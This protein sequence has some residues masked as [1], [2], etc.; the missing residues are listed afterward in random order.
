MKYIISHI[1]KKRLKRVVFALI[2]LGGI[3]SP[4]LAKEYLNRKSIYE[5]VINRSK[6]D[7]IIK[8]SWYASRLLFVKNPEIYLQSDTIPLKMMESTKGFLELYQTKSRSIKKLRLLMQSVYR[9]ENGHT[10]KLSNIDFAKF[11]VIKNKYTLKNRRVHSF[12]YLDER[13]APLMSI[14]K[15]TSS[16][17]TS[18]ELAFL[19][20]LRLKQ[21]GKK[22]WILY[23]MNQQAYI[24]VDK[25]FFLHGR[26]ISPVPLDP[27]L[28]IFNN[29]FC[30]SSVLKRDDRKRSIALSKLLN[31][32]PP[33]KYRASIPTMQKS[34]ISKILSQTYIHNKLDKTAALHAAGRYTLPL[35][36]FQ[37]Y[38]R[39]Y[40]NPKLLDL[41]FFPMEI[42][43]YNANLLHPFSWYF[44]KKHYK[45][46]NTQKRVALI[47]KSYRKIFYEPGLGLYMF[48]KK[49]PFINQRTW[50]DLGH[51]FCP[52]IEDNL[53]AKAGVC[54][55][56]TLIASAILDLMNVPNYHFSVK[57][58][59]MI[60]L[61]QW[62]QLYSNGVIYSDL[63]NRK[64][65]YS[66]NF[67]RNNLFMFRISKQGKVFVFSNIKKEQ[68]FSLIPKQM[69][70]SFIKKAT[71]RFGEKL[72]F[73]AT[74]KEC[75]YSKKMYSNLKR[76]RF[77]LIK[78]L[79]RY[80]KFMQ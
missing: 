58:H 8:Y 49:E 1:N 76:K 55:E 22:P 71:S 54:R 29:K 30:Y 65:S 10:L 38:K 25:K 43:T 24:Y 62:N 16:Q 18:L 73:G 44:A 23:T 27:I 39:L 53:F 26:D 46:R 7:P 75:N 67:I 50:G 47:F 13:I 45:E 51:F 70:L 34:I 72:R 31:K 9:K 15:R 77:V 28:V 40:P 64:D 63:P 52:G 33:Q 4:L 57:H 19:Y 42:W 36:R 59:T 2:I 78:D 56:N 3:Y 80:L 11:T 35:A 60:W 48:S 61:S 6:K 68:L 14:L 74:L 5:D 32:I 12:S 37:A 66:Y 41:L 79:R 69:I 21:A 17:L 20:W